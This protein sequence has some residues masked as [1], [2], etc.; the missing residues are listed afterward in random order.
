MESKKKGA[1][2]Q[3]PYILNFKFP[4]VFAEI[5]LVLIDLNL[6]EITFTNSIAIAIDIIIN[7]INERKL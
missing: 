1:V 7:N 3:L 4:F 5:N 2:A 6:Y